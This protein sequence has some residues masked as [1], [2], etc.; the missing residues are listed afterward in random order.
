[1]KKILLTVFAALLLLSATACSPSKGQVGSVITFGNYE[2]DNNTTDGK[3]EIEWIVLDRQD[4]NLLLISKY[5]LDY[6]PYNTDYEEVNWESCTVRAWLND[7]FLS[8][9]FSDDEQAMI[10]TT[11]V[12]AEED[13]DPAI[14]I[15]NDTQDKVFLLNTSEADKYFSS[16]DDRV[17][18]ATAY[19]IAQAQIPSF[20]GDD[21]KTNC[22]WW[23]RS[24]GFDNYGVAYIYSDGGINYNGGG[25]NDCDCALRPALWVHLDENR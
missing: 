9:A 8:S 20:P 6:M 2:Q 19:A 12:V 25:V 10:L 7:T 15:G 14:D 24:P 21:G 3:E 22:W 5:A 11:T 13:P 17:C 23:L 18:T 1:M 16:A 4:D